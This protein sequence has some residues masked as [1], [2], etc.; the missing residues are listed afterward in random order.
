[1][2]KEA[3]IEYESMLDY[4]TSGQQYCTETYTT[5]L[6]NLRVVIHSNHRGHLN[7]WKL[8]NYFISGH[9]TAVLIYEPARQSKFCVLMAR[10][11]PSQKAH[12]A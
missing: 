1:M 10:V 7:H 3:K 8:F 5:T 2:N 11:N 9:V 6:L 4:E 12:K